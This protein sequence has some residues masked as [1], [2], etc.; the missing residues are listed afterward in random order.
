[1]PSA[2]GPVEIVDGDDADPVALAR[3]IQ[4]LPGDACRRLRDRVIDVHHFFLT[5]FTGAEPCH[6]GCPVARVV[7]VAQYVTP[8]LSVDPA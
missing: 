1:M 3:H 2:R 5:E 8:G 7:A 4:V 6:R